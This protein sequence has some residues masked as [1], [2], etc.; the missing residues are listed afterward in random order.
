[1]SE[2]QK[3][4]SVQYFNCLCVGKYDTYNSTHHMNTNKHKAHIQRSELLQ[5]IERLKNLITKVSTNS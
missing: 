3:K 2:Y 5:E 1:M 4:Y